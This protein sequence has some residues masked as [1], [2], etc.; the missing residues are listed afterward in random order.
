[1]PSDSDTAGNDERAFDVPPQFFKGAVTSDDVFTCKEHLKE[2]VGAHY[3][4][5]NPVDDHRREQ[6]LWPAPKSVRICNYLRAA[7]PNNFLLIPA[8]VGDDGSRVGR[9]R[10]SSISTS[11]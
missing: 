7:P 4:K 11:T 1:M 9:S 2:G 3:T 6:I 8:L 10:S 5:L